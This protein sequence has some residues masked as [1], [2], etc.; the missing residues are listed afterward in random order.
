MNLDFSV[1]PVFS[2][3][4]VALAVSG[5]A[6][7]ALGSV[8]NALS[9]GGR[10]FFVLA[11]LAFVGYAYYLAFVFRGG[12]Y[13]LYYQTFAIPVLLVAHWVKALT[14]RRN[15]AP[16]PVPSAAPYDPSVP[17]RGAA[18]HDPSAPREAQPVPQQPAPPQQPSA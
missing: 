11:G 14:G 5:I 13:R 4:V 8:N 18:P 1:D 7:I 10:L 17:Y 12:E 6:I 9:A 3:Y 16:Q 2:W 15:Q